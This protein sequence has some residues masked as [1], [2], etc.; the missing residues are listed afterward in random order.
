VTSPA[1]WCAEPGKGQI[2]A[3][4]ATSLSQALQSLHDDERRPRR[5]WVALT[6]ALEWASQHRAPAD[7]QTGPT[8]IE[9]LLNALAAGTGARVGRH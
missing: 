5:R 2:A 1:A 6:L 3:L 4:P 9:R 7:R 8:W